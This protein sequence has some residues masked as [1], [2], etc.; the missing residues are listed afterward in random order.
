M[1]LPP[2]DPDQPLFR[3]TLNMSHKHDYIKKEGKFKKRTSYNQ[4]QKTSCIICQII[5]R[6]PE[7]DAYEIYRDEEF[8]I[9]LNLFPYTSGHILVSPIE[10]LVEYEEFPEELTYRFAK[11]MQQLIRLVKTEMRSS[12]VNVGWNQ[13]PFAGGSIKHWHAHIVPRYPSELNFIEIIA[14]TRP[15][16]QAL[17]TTQSILKDK[18]SDYL[19]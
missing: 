12:S 10:H 14:Q 6:D 2:G 19:E 5:N 17:E 13:G 8:I 1:E 7:V 18:I 11:L 4:Q 16:I 15:V 9:F 3:S